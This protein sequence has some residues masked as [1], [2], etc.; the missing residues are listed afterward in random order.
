M[1]LADDLFPRRGGEIHLGDVSLRTLLELEAT[2][3]YVLDMGRV[4]QRLAALNALD[5]SMYF[6]VK[7][8]ANVEL[9]RRLAGLGL[10]ADVCSPGDVAFAEAAGLTPDRLSYTSTSMSSAEVAWVAGK[11]IFFVAD[12][13]AQ[14]DRYGEEAPGGRL[15]IRVNTGIEAGFH[16]AVVASGSTS[17]FGIPLPEVPDALARAHRAGLKVTALHGHLGSDILDPGPHLRLLDALLSI[18]ATIPSV[19]AVDLGGGWGVPFTDVEPEYDL[20]RLSAGVDARLVKFHRRHGRRPELRLEPGTYLVRD[21]G[22]LVARVVERTRR[23]DS[24]QLGLDS[25]TNHLPGALLF[26][27]QHVAVG[28]RV[29]PSE[30]PRAVVVGNLLQGGDVLLRDA[31]LG[32]LEPGD[33]VVFGLAGAYTGVRASTFNQRPR[34]ATLLVDVRSVTRVRRAERV[35]D[36]LSYEC[37]AE[38]L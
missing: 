12:S 20:A 15:G 33:T 30:A 19:A 26:G 27:T 14:I 36:L 7:A 13:V 37:S 2:P 10:A 34:P 9:V 4:R 1:T 18:A 25:S 28:S 8:N 5:A 23:G 22:Y 24:V 16:P 21:A 38:L 11:G 17:K 35:E 6:A 29:H 3:F 32:H 31:P